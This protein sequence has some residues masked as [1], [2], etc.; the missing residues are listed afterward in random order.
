MTIH[1]L[2]LNEAKAIQREIVVC[3][4]G[5][6]LTFVH[7]ASVSGNASL[8]NRVQPLASGENSDIQKICEK[9]IGVIQTVMTFEVCIGANHLETK[10]VWNVMPDTIVGLNPYGENN[11]S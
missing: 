3:F 10:A 6:V 8:V 5:K 1:L 9:C 11:Y 2:L 4:S 7:R